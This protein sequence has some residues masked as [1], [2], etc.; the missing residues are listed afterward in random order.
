MATIL[1]TSDTHLDRVTYNESRT[2]D[3]DMVLAEILAI[4]REVK[5]DL[6]LHTGDLF[7]APRPSTDAMHRAVAWLQEL[8]AVSRSGVIVICGNHESARL[9]ALFARILGPESRIRFV[10]KARAP[11]NGGII[12]LPGP[13]DERIRVAP[14]PFIHVNRV[15]DEEVFSD[16]SKWTGTYADY[17]NSVERVLGQGLARGADPTRDVL[18]FAAHLHVAGAKFSGS[19]RQLHISDIYGSNL[20]TLP[21]V[22]YAAF[23]HIHRPQPLPGSIVM[24][25]YAG[26][27]IQMDFG[28]L[29]EEKSVV[30]VEARP[31]MPSRIER[32]KLSGG[33]Q[34]RRLSGT[35]D[36]IRVQAPN[37]GNALCLVTVQTETHVIDL[38]DQIREL[39]PDATLLQVNEECGENKIHA[40]GRG[41]GVG[42]TAEPG[43]DELF[44]DYLAQKGTKG[45]SA[46]RIHAH[47][48]ALIAAVGE[49][50]APEF[51]EEA[52]L[53]DG[54]IDADRISKREPA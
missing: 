46:D 6:V 51:P 2:P 52:F 40:L 49:D 1:H 16:A 29:D 17:V 7:D 54:T 13:R 10:D 42:A 8:A 30:V 14:L 21:V 4:A 37:I 5:P 45:G 34:L 43:F 47:F 22:N 25:T 44:H 20:E 28:E 33:R 35:V 31:Q 27:P 24:G 32:R 19:E 15:L 38:A 36:E 9:F 11:Q 26:S 48:K 39:L 23:G 18:L 3:H 53:A 41:D 50:V 12:D